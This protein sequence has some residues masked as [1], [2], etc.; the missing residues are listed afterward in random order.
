[1]HP[2]GSGSMMG[3]G[4][5]VSSNQGINTVRDPQMQQFD[6]TLQQFVHVWKTDKKDIAGV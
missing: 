6:K 1:M 2:N 5:S 4:Y 3:G